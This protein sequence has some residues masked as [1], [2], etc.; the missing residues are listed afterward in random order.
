M[1]VKTGS[2]NYEANRVTAA[3]V[4]REARKSELPPS[5]NVNA[6]PPTMSAD[7]PSTDLSYWTSLNKLQH[8]DDTTRYSPSTSASPSTPKINTD[9]AS[10]IPL[11]PSSSSSSSY[12][13][14]DSTS[15]TAAPVPITTAHNPDTATTLA[16]WTRPVPVLIAAAPPPHTS[17]CSTHTPPSSTLTTISSSTL[18]T[19][20]TPN[21]PSPMNTPLRSAS[22]IS[23][24]T[25]TTI[26]E[27]YT[28]TADY[29]CRHRPCTFTSP[30]G[31]VGHLHTHCIDTGEPVPETPTQPRRIRHHCS[32]SPS[33]HSLSTWAY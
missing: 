22:T 1:T 21:M 20:N 11:R 18:S 31:L 5:R 28:D 3:K 29:S 10:E 15:V 26:C 7:V 27:T 17:A 33:A 4:K 2:A 16:M 19:S 32:R 23:S 9:R 12:S 14:I 24:S 6:Q 25:T 13:S 8:S 30:I